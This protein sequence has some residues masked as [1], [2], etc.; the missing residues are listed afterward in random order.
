MRADA[1]TGL[2]RQLEMTTPDMFVYVT[3]RPRDEHD[4]DGH[5]TPSKVLRATR[6][7]SVTQ[8]KAR[9]EVRMT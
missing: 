4:A 6:V 5:G 9:A 8:R 7:L 2:V 1:V 3:A